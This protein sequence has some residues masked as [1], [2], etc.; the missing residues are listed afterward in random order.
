MDIFDLKNMKKKSG[1]TNADIAALSGIP[2]ST[3]N[4]IFSGATENPRYGTLLAIEQ[5]LVGKEKIPFRYD[6]M[7]QEPCLIREEAANYCYDAR[8][9]KEDDIERLDEGTRAELIDGKLYLL[10]APNRMHQF[11]IS[12]ITFQLK[13]HIREKE[14][15]CHVYTAPFAVRLFDD[16][17]TEVQPDIVVICNKDI[18]TDKGCDGAPDIIYEIVSPGNISHD[19]ITKL[20]K[21]QKAGVREY[22]IVNPEQE[23]ISVLNFENAEKTDE[24]TYEDVISSSV[25][26]GFAIRMK[27]F[28]GE[29]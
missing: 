14:G 10:A 18:M 1:M 25:L 2:I 27:D 3:V 19:Y 16:D 22:W 6:E 20:M 15:K 12:E 7:K 13:S 23:R 5:V 9:Y 26:S 8:V 17:K 24:Y 21:Y 11:L 4:K 29:Y 28:L